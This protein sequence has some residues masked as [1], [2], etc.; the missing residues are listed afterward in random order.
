MNAEVISVNISTETGTIKEP[1]PEITIDSRGVAGDAHAGDWHRQVSVLSRELIDGFRQQMNRTIKNGEFAENIT[2]RG[3]DL[4]TVGVMDRLRI[5]Q[6]ELEVAQIGKECHGDACAIFR[7]VG[8]CVMPKE[9]VF[10]RVLQGGGVRPGN[11]IKHV[12]RPLR[13]L[14][15]TASDRA[16]SG[17]YEDR[18]GPQ[19]EASLDAFFAGTRWHPE[20]RLHIIPDDTAVLTGVLASFAE[21]DGDV[22]VITGG[23]GI[24]PR[25]VTPE[26]VDAFCDKT[27]PGIMEAIRVKYGAEKPS[28]LLSRSVAG[29]K[30]RML[31][32][33]IPGS[34]RAAREYMEEILKTM[35]HAILMLNG[36]NA[37]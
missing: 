10:C 5:G 22:A 28:A 21:E 27:I 31:V 13:I 1:V 33:A 35:E 17:T 11:S 8:K 6:A 12:R 23:T 34:V 37:H 7:E 25:D 19:V 18:S 29:I 15:V 4:Q 32:Y 9:G 24:G 30:G 2:T 26:A 36:I 20:I 3:L 14:V 16:S